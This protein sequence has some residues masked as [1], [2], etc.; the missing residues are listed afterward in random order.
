ML[1]IPYYLFRWVLY[2]VPE[3][4]QDILKGWRQRRELVGILASWLLLNHEHLG[5]S[6]SGHRRPDAEGTENSCVT[7][8]T[9]LASRMSLK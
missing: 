8:S 3:C 1:L 5:S 6:S 9:A 7:P 4:L 2:Q